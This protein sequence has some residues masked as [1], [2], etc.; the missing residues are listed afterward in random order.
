MT[1]AQRRRYEQ[2][3]DLPADYLEQLGLEHGRN[4]QILQR[5]Q[6]LPKKSKCLVFAC[7]VEHAE[8]LTIALNRLCGEGSAMVVTAHTPRSE[9][10]DAIDRFLTDPTLRFICNVGVLAL[11]FDAPR[12]NVVCVTRP[13]A[14]ALRYEQMVGRG[15]RGPKNG[16]TERCL[17]LDVQDV[18]LPDGIQSYGRVKELWDGRG[19]A[20]GD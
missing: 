13:T 6:R 1:P 4:A 7:S 16:G 5:L 9:R 17:V 3:R 8:I 10:A 15:L 11:G 2:F 19:R 18:G 20:T 14:S 12:A